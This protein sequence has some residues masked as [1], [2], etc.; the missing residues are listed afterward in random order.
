MNNQENLLN[1]LPLE[2]FT[3]AEELFNLFRY[4]GHKL[5]MVV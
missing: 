4:H 1:K 2:L 5:H 3:E